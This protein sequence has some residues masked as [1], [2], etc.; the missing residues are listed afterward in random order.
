[1]AKNVMAKKQNIET[2]YAQRIAAYVDSP[3]LR[4]RIKTEN[5]ISCVINGN[6][7]NYRVTITF[8]KNRVKGMA[9]TSPS[10][11]RPCKHAHALLLTYEKSPA[12][13]LE[14][15]ELLKEL[16]KRSQKDL[17]KLVR[18]MI[19]GAPACLKVLGVKGFDNPSEEEYDEE[20]W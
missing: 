20:P 18:Q 13:F 12:S 14:I 8:G 17:L 6:Y 11:Y 1:M 5:T 15:E 10:D 16:E 19:A 2:I 4:Q 9:C 3:D 7:G